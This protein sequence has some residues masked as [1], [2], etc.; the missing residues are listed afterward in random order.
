VDLSAPVDHALVH[1][2]ERELCERRRGRRRRACETP[3]SRA[4]GRLPAMTS[5]FASP[6]VTPPASYFPSPIR[7]WSFGEHIRGWDAE[8]KTAGCSYLL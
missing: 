7:I 1:A 8:T 4:P 3:S 6:R 2:G 5:G